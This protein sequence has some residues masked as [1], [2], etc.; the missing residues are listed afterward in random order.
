MLD[1]LHA[2]MLFRS[3]MPAEALDLMF[4]TS[5]RPQLPQDWRRA[6]A[7]MTKQIRRAVSYR[8]NA[9]AMAETS[10]TQRQAALEKTYRAEKIL[11]SLKDNL[12]VDFSG[13]STTG[14]LNLSAMI[15]SALREYVRDARRMI[16]G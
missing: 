13:P 8:A 4:A 5:K 7:R 6:L 3:H 14:K 2:Q 12:N 16:R 11:D 9:V 15:V 1:L 10:R